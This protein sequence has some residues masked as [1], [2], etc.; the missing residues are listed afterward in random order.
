M[1]ARYPIDYYT[2]NSIP[3]RISLREQGSLATDDPAFSMARGIFRSRLLF[4]RD[5]MVGGQYPEGANVRR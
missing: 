2:K 3:A 1:L 4:Q 5:E